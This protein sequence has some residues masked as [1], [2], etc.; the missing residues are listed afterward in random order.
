MATIAEVRA[1]YPQYSDMSDEAL[2]DALYKKFYSDIPRA[3]FD[4]KVGLKPVA[5]APTAPEPRSEGMPTAP[6]Q[7]IP[8]GQITAPFMGFSSGVGNVMF[9]GQE[10]IGRGLQ[11]IGAQ[12]TGAALAADA[13]R[14]RAQEQAKIQPYKEQFPIATGAGEFAGEVVSTLPVGGAIA[15]PVRAAGAG[16][17]AQAIRTGGL[18]T[19]AAPA[20]TLGGRL[21]DL[22][23]RVSGGAITG[24]ATAGLINPNEIET[25]AAVGGVVAAAAPPV[26]QTLSKSAG[27]LKDLFTGRLSSIK[28]GEVSRATAGD[29]IAAIRAALAAAPEDLTAAQ[30]AAGVQKNAFQALGKFAEKSDEISLKLKQQ[31]SNDLAVLQRMAEG[32]NETEMRRA[33][34]ESIKRLNQLTQDMRNVELNAANQAAQTL[35][36]LA[37]QLEQRQASMVNALRGGIPIGAPLPGQSVL[38]PVTEAAKAT[39]RAQEQFSRV[40]PGQIP[41]ISARQA[42][43]T[44]MAAAKQWQETADIYSDIARQRRT[45]ADFIERQIGSLSDYGLQP[46]NAN[47]VVNAI[48]AKL[49]QPGL[50]ASPTITKVLSTIKDD[51]NYLTSKGGGIIDAHDLYTLRKEGINERINQ[52]LGQTDPKVSAKVTS[53]VLQEVRPLIDDAIER[54]GGTGWRDYLKTYAQNMQA[55]DQKAMASQAVKL[56][57]TSPKEYTR[58]VRGNNPDAVEA[59]FGPGSYDIFKEMGRKM[60]TLE[61]VAANIERTEAMADAASKG[62]EKF[63]EAVESIGR[64]FPRLPNPLNPKIT[65]ANMTLDELEDRLGP[66]IAEKLRQGMVSGRSALEMLNTLPSVER[67]KVLRMLNNPS[68][69]GKT[70]A[71]IMKSATV[72]T[73][74]PVSLDVSGTAESMSPAERRLAEQVRMEQR[75]MLNPNQSNQ[76]NLM[77]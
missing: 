61:K 10:L 59:I 75:N 17:L 18:S 21:A 48:D 74:P 47:T 67:D 73:T 50:R 65:Y 5:P 51:I 30:A 53:K 3:D 4:T 58:L 45:E 12:E 54:A 66:K 42:G 60:P 24:G 49:S 11:A 9:G 71:T 52:I 6:R 56:F 33:Y 31:A 68:T 22:G 23:T 15:A 64:T 72:A 1:K 44:Q 76:N 2:A 19:G 36:R 20:T 34:E 29:Q 25:G 28:A 57:E 62:K 13:A 41:E 55:I 26:V 27:F 35:N 7:D 77:R 70:G 37:P 16:R 39:T 38:S 63:A 32:G 43:R 14:R 8:F 40:V 69:W 46:L